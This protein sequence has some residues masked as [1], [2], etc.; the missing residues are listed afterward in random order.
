MPRTRVERADAFAYKHEGWLSSFPAGA[1]ATL[2]ALTGQFAR[3]G[4][5]GL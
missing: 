1:V 3:A 4:T 5:E 2:K